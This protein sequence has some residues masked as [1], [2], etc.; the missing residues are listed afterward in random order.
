MGRRVAGARDYTSAEIPNLPERISNVITL[1][2]APVPGGWQRGPDS[3]LLDRT[4]RYLRGDA[5]TPKPG[6]E[7]KLELEILA[8]DPAA[9]VTTCFGARLIDGINAV[10]LARDAGGRR[11]GNVEADML[12]LTADAAGHRTQLLVEAKTSSDNAWYAVIESLRQLKLFQLSQQRTT[13]S[14]AAEVTTEPISH[15]KPSSS[16]PRSSTAREEPRSARPT[17]P[18]SCWQHSRPY[19]TSRFASPPGTQRSG[20]SRRSR[21]PDRAR[22]QLNRPLRR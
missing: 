11:R 17:P 16:P 8:P 21:W 7:H 1:W 20:A 14:T 22:S 2:T 5:A 13:S 3:R 12:L 6:S 10:P 18:G 15:S 19:R 9:T 4:Q